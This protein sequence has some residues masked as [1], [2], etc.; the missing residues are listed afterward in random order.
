MDYRMH[1]AYN[2]LQ[3]HAYA[4]RHYIDNLKNWKSL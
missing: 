2:I 4:Q 1:Y 3:M